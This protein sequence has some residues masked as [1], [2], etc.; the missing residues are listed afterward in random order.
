MCSWQFC[1]CLWIFFYVHEV[2]TLST[3]LK[4]VCCLSNNVSCEIIC[5][6][7]P[8]SFY[9]NHCGLALF[10]LSAYISFFN[11][12]FIFIPIRGIYEF[13]GDTT[14]EGTFPFFYLCFLLQKNEIYI[15]T[16][17]QEI[18]SGFFCTRYLT[19]WVSCHS[20]LGLLIKS[21]FHFGLNVYSYSDAS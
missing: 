7:W 20:Q 8:S 14:R 1:C 5:H 3:K 10:E 6:W 21:P 9:Q 12:I 17:I 13:I 16:D 11:F 18:R 2:W 19:K 4:Y 15:V